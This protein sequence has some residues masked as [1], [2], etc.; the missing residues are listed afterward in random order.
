MSF[1]YKVNPNLPSQI[2]LDFAHKSGLCVSEWELCY[3][4]IAVH[5]PLLKFMRGSSAC[6]EVTSDFGQI[7]SQPTHYTMYRYLA[8]HFMKIQRKV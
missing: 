3:L 7:Y 6:W 1:D 5:I 4:Q 8:I 2:V